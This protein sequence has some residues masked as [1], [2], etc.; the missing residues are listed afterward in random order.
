MASK[1]TVTFSGSQAEA[2]LKALGQVPKQSKTVEAL[3]AKVAEAKNA[4]A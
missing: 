1:V 4:A 3:A 2:L